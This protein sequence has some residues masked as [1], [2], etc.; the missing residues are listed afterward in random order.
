MADPTF[1]QI[2]DAPGFKILVDGGDLSTE[3]LVDVL[4]VRV[5]DYVDG[6][7]VFTITMNNWHSDQQE[8]KWVDDDQFRL[9]TE[10]EVRMGFGDDMVSLIVGE[11]TA[12][13]PDFPDNEAPTLK[14]QGYDRLHRL[15]RGRKTRSFVDVKDS[16][17][18]AQ[19]ASDLGLLDQVDDSEVTYTYVL[20]D[21][22][23]DVDFLLERARRINFEVV[24]QGDTL[25]F[26]RVANDQSEVITLTYGMTLRSFYPRMTVVGQTNE[27]TV[28][29]W[30]PMNKEAVVGTARVGDETSTMGGNDL[31]ASLAE[32][33]FGEAVE[34]I[35]QDPVT[36]EGEAV[37]V[38]RGRFNRIVNR[39]VTGEGLAVG[40]GHIRAGSVIKLEGLGER[41]SG[42][43][44]V[45]SSTHQVSQA[46]Y[47]TRFTVSR[48]AI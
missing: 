22:Q 33:A 47:T 38:A 42:L 3:A 27:V 21:N 20:Q 9:G 17:I 2:R 44:Y 45:T 18:A 26:R 31:G 7:S 4:D 23:S 48:S 43:Y 12:L 32:Q 30:D 34:T 1:G 19:I 40:D 41:F 6:P 37:K 8:F 5:S 35:V 36:S 46:G 11:V 15:R 13:E 39:F 24:V 10:I 28:R 16:D 29:G 25:Y 14:V